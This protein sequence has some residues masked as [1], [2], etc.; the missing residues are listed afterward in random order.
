MKNTNRLKG[1]PFLLFTVLLLA[2]TLSGC[3]HNETYEARESYEKIDDIEKTEDD[4]SDSA[5]TV[6]DAGN[7]E[8]ADASDDKSDEQNDETDADASEQKTDG[9][10]KSGG[11]QNMELLPELTE[12]ELASLQYVEKIT[13]ED[14]YGDHTEYEAYVPIDTQ[15][16]DGFAF[17]YGHGLTYSGSAFNMESTALMLD[18]MNGMVEFDMDDWGGEDSGYSEIEFGDVVRSGDDR[19]RIATAMKE[20]YYGTP[21]AVKK[22]YFM[23]QQSKGA[24]VVWSLELSEIEADDETDAVIDEMARC[25]RVNLDV[26]KSSGEWQ[27][28]DAERREQQQDVYEPEA[29]D[30]VLE[31]VDGYRYMGLTMINDISGAI[32]CPVMVPMGWNTSVQDYFFRANMHGVKV[33]GD[34]TELYND[35][36]SNA[37]SSLDSQYGVYERNTE[38][39]ANPQV[40]GLEPIGG[41]GMARYA[42]ITYEEW[43]YGTEEFLPQAKVMCFIR[44]RKDYILNYSITLSFEDYDDATDTLI[45]ELEVAYGIDLSEYYY[46]NVK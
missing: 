23:D 6:D 26:I 33:S 13:I 19:Y 10:Q 24:G 37:Q 45:K 39:Y 3:G 20:D 8:S 21:Y 25:Y 28:G 40:T 2:V 16:E 1:K 18:Y 7:Q 44:V 30:R 9:E 41:Y 35:F 38:S 11:E 5:H 42:V 31:L 29:G 34:L 15:N 36:L 12:E 46:E 32:Q 43:D 4:K 17:S 27:V 22:V 14:F